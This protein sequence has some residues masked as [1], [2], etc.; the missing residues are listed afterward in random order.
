MKKG[1]LQIARL[2]IPF[3]Y[4][5]IDPPYLRGLVEDTISRIDRAGVF[6]PDTW[7]VVQHSK[8]EPVRLADKRYRVE[9][10]RTYGDS[11]LTF[12]QINKQ[13]DEN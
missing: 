11:T 8:W 1:I 9:D 12:I 2:N 5:F 10:Q 6:K 4:I 13:A 3:D 7:I